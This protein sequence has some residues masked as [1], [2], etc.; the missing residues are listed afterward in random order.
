M[1]ELDR[2][3]VTKLIF[4][5]DLKLPPS[6]VLL[7]NFLGMTPVQVKRVLKMLRESGAMT[8]KT[9]PAKNGL[10]LLGTSSESSSARLR[11]E[12]TFNAPLV[13]Q[14]RRAALRPDT[15]RYRDECSIVVGIK[16]EV[17]AF[18]QLQSPDDDRCVG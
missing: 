5:H 13:D 10:E 14:P 1:R 8:L 2:R 11:L 17:G 9:V 4:E 6:Q 3:L 18:R 12:P 16:D 7:P 15:L